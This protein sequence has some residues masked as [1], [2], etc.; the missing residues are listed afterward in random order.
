MTTCYVLHDLENKLNPCK[1]DTDGSMT[2]VWCNKHCGAYHSCSLRN[3]DENHNAMCHLCC[4]EQTMIYVDH[5]HDDKNNK[6]CSPRLLDRRGAIIG[7]L[8]D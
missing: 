2:R 7:K 5:I 8:P 3:N 4:S 1:I 6:N